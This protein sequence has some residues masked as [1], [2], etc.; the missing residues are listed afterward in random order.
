M[1]DKPDANKKT[2]AVR[3]RDAATL[4]LIRRTSAAPEVLMGQRSASAKFMPNKYVFPGGRVDAADQRIRTA[5]DLRP[6]VLARLALHG[7]A[8]RARALALAAVRE[9][10]EEAGL[11]LAQKV[12]RAERSRSEGWAGFLKLGIAPD[13]SAMTYIARAITPPYRDRRF[14]TRFFI[15]EA[16]RLFEPPDYTRNESGELLSLSW[17]PIADAKK[18]D[19]PTITATVLE[20]IE[21]RADDPH[22]DRPIPF[23]RM[24][25]GKPKWDTI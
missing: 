7:G 9:T 23:F 18:L 1:F 3:P 8:A 20:E 4:I 22:A 15:A 16:D 10:Y 19:L 11:I 12:A 2:R 13:L 24:A 14:D 21:R 17:F 6:E 5:H 25:H